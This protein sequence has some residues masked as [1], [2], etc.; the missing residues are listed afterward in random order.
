MLL[1]I[2][3]FTLVFSLALYRARK[4]QRAVNG[5]LNS[6]GAVMYNVGLS[7]PMDPFGDPPDEEDWSSSVPVADLLFTVVA[8]SMRKNADWYQGPGATDAEMACLDDLPY[9][10]SLDLSTTKI[11][12]AGL[13]HVEELTRLEKLQLQYTGVG[14]AGVQH[15]Q[16]LNCLNYLDLSGTKVTDAGLEHLKGLRRLRHLFLQG[17]KVTKDGVEKLRQAMPNTQIEHF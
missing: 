1:A 15:L 2:A 5:I 11:S 13:V 4:Q 7:L 17:S 6:G 12:D 8:V 10:W 16:G 14:D 9:V 3:L